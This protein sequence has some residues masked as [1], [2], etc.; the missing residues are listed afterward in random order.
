MS[1]NVK[2]E[3]CDTRWDVGLLS[4]CTT[5]P[6]ACNGIAME[7]IVRSIGVDRYYFI[8]NNYLPRYFCS[9]SIKVC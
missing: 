8:D 9:R 2:G 1:L 6:R 7:R 5:R 3:K 4:P